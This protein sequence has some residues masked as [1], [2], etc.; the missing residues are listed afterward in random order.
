MFE[1]EIKFISD[2]SLNRIKR[3]GAFFTFE[4][5]CGA[6]LHPAITKYIDSEF[7]YLIYQDRKKLLQKS[8]FDY[9]GPE[10]QKYFRLI[11]QEI[12][13]NKKISFEDSRNLIMQAVS[14]TVNFLVRPKWSLTKFIYNEDQLKSVDEIKLSLNYLYYY[15][16]LKSVL[17]IYIEKKKSVN[18]SLIDFEVALNKIVKELL[19][20]HPQ[21][22]IDNA[23]LSMA[24]FFNLGALDNTKVSSN[25]VEIFLKEEEMIDHL[26][27]LRRA[28]PVNI[29]QQY[30]ID[31]IRKIIYTPTSIDKPEVLPSRS[32][33][34]APESEVE[35]KNVS[36]PGDPAC[37]AGREVKNVN[38]N[39]DQ[40]KT[41]KGEL[42]I[43]ENKEIGKEAENPGEEIE[44]GKTDS[45]ELDNLLE[46]DL[47]T[48]VSTDDDLLESFDSQLKA[49]EEE[50]GL[51][52]AGDENTPFED[53]AQ[54]QRTGEKEDRKTEN[55]VRD[56]GHFEIETE[57]AEETN[58]VN[59][60][61]EPDKILF[62]SSESTTS[63]QEEI[64]EGNI[65]EEEKTEVMQQPH[66]TY[67]VPPREKD[68]L[69]FLSDKEIGKIINNVFNGDRQDF[70]NTME[71]ITE[72]STYDGATE[73]L[74]SVFFSY[75]VNPYIRDAVTLTNAV[76]NYFNQAI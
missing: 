19:T 49:L 41:E 47:L 30:E 23:L 55:N 17:T 35:I 36:E 57:S 5:L 74:K 46:E 16:Y 27:R 37:P 63:R 73:I 3:L 20:A 15:D 24:D 11:N 9:S 39:F 59:K 18:F 71:K 53:D 58:K 25:C 31:E 64:N 13:K 40:K 51:M 8:A 32:E 60:E 66:T 70:A 56:E 61:P 21:K 69:S 14:F 7:D 50:S 26:F 72:C 52:I 34:T 4:Q 2:F 22:I 10:I 29:K 67:K 33:I 38:E 43:A 76:S 1:K 12:K 42:P 6:G 28:L 45:N 65:Q 62:N 48:E 75:R 54:K 44:Q 68:V